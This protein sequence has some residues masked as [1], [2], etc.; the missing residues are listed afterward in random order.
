MEVTGEAESLPKPGCGRSNRGQADLTADIVRTATVA[1]NPRLSC[2]LIPLLLVFY[3]GELVWRERDAGLS[4][5]ADACPVLKWVLFLGSS[6]DSL[7]R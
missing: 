6:W 2:V 7:S 4:E 5:I 3:A 1:D